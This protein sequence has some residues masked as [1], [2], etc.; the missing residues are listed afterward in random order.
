MCFIN[1]SLKKR[2]EVLFVF[3]DDTDESTSIEQLIWLEALYR[4]LEP[5]VNCI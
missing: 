3:D 2:M 1:R 4:A 5:H